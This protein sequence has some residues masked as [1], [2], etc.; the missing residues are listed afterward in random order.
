MRQTIII[1]KNYIIG[2]CPPC[3]FDEGILSAY[4]ELH[5]SDFVRGIL[6]GGFCPTLVF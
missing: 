3:K 6:S 5:E 1:I 4:V 2:F